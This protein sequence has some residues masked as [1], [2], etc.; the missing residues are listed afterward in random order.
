MSELKEQLEYAV[1]AYNE[2][3]AT[4]REL[5]ELVNKHLERQKRMTS[6]IQFLNKE[7]EKEAEY[8]RTHA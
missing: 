7:L 8:Y 2:S 1:G 5:T 4:T 6:Q 3:V